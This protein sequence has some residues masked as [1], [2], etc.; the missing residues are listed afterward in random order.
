MPGEISDF[1]AMETDKALGDNPSGVFQARAN[2][3]EVKAFRIESTFITP[4][5]YQ[6][7]AV[8]W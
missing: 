3:P 1:N 5:K 7:L 8:V 2:Y 4:F 6:T